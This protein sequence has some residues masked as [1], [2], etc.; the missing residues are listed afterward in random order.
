[1]R[2][3][4][5][6]IG[7]MF[8]AGTG[9]VD[10]PSPPTAG[11]PG[12][13]QGAGP[14]GTPPGPGAHPG[15]GDPMTPGGGPAKG[16]QGQRASGPLQVALVPSARSAGLLKALVARLDGPRGSGKGQGKGKGKDKDKASA[17]EVDVWVPEGDRLVSMELTRQ[18]L[19]QAIGTK[20]APTLVPQGGTEPVESA[21]M[22]GAAD[23][24]VLPG[25]TVIRLTDTASGPGHTLVVVAQL[26]QS[27]GENSELVVAAR[28]G[29]Q[30]KAATASRSASSG[31]LD[32]VL[33]LSGLVG[34]APRVLADDQ[35]VPALVEGE[36]DL[37]V[38]PAHR[39][40]EAFTSGAAVAWRSL[41]AAEAAPSVAVHACPVSTVGNEEARRA[42]QALLGTYR[43][44][45]ERRADSDRATGD[46]HY[47]PDGRVDVARL[48]SMLATL[49]SQERIGHAELE[50]I[51][52]ETRLESGPPEGETVLLVDNRLV[53]DR[54][55]KGGP[56][57]KPKGG[58]GGGS[59]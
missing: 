6:L 1:M 22:E 44:F 21:L 41:E 8:L 58:G 31:D 9:C 29:T 15:P 45:L 34:D 26:G 11:P 4:G 51:D 13:S 53:A 5:W 25:A 50:I 35:L 23:C 54:R 57:R 2:M 3:I 46:T 12:P 17:L 28:P 59:E 20:D 16:A 52:L 32:A 38:A 18:G 10:V 39:L 56:A 40:E 37:V 19:R 48:Q 14:P 24:A 30:G 49:K 55:G 42:L 27:G 33:V 47:P 43:G 7:A 36:V